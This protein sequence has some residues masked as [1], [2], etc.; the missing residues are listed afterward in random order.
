MSDSEK[1]E[2]TADDL[3]GTVVYNPPKK[4]RKLKPAR[5][6]V[7]PGQVVKEEPIQTGKEYSEDSSDGLSLSTVTNP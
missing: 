5:K 1:P 2:P 3:P 4:Q 6:Q 7:K